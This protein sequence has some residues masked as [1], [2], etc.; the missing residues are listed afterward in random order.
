[1]VVQELGRAMS[2]DRTCRLQKTYLALRT[3]LKTSSEKLPDQSSVEQL[4]NIH[5][6][7]EEVGQM[8]DSQKG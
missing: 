1:M 6:K 5:K 7:F 3:D 8:I 4:K 2:P